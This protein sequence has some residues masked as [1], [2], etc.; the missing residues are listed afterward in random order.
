MSRHRLN[1]KKVSERVLKQRILAVTASKPENFIITD[2]TQSYDSIQL[3]LYLAD[4]RSREVKG[5]DLRRS[6]SGIASLNPAEETDV[7]LLYF[8]CVL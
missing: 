8:F 2:Y 1:L 7:R 3:I 6:T 5:A 4:P